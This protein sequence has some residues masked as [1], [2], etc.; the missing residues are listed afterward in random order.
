M[1]KIDNNDF[2]EDC[3]QAADLAKIDFGIAAIVN[4]WGDSVSIYAGTL[5]ASHV[6]AVEEAKTHYR[7][8]KVTGMDV[9]IANTYA[10]VNEA[11]I[12]MDAAIPAVNA[13]GGDIVLIT[14]APEGQITHYLGGP[15]GK[16]TWAKKPSRQE[17]PKNIGSVIVYSEFPHPGSSWF[18]EDTRILYMNK[19]EDV[20]KLL[21]KSHG[22]GTKVAVFPD[23]TNQFV[24]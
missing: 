13:S 1:G 21:E 5:R 3:D 9:V 16:T 15:C 17:L 10:K 14:N 8:P 19:W 7:T 11:K 22:P 12:G 24:A 18:D 2:R 4:E 6:R 23:A 20:I